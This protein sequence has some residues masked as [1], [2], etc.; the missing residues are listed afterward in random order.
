MIKRYTT[1]EQVC[2]NDGVLSRYVDG[3]YDWH[4]S[5]KLHDHEII[6]R[7][8]EQNERIQELETE[9][10]KLWATCNSNLQFARKE[11][12]TIKRDDRG[13]YKVYSKNVIPKDSP[14]ISITAPSV[15]FN[16]YILNHIIEA[17][18]KISPVQ[19]GGVTD[20]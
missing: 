19:L 8:N 1:H 4:T 20:D 6:D 14:I 12:I 17:I 15:F 16:E 18:D 2:T 7:L 9:N 13:R 11:D 10:D 3:V 5:E